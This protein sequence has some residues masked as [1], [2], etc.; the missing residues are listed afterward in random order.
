MQAVVPGF[1]RMPEYIPLVTTP[2]RDSQLSHF[3]A[4]TLFILFVFLLFQFC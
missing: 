3:V 1:D 2:R 4:F